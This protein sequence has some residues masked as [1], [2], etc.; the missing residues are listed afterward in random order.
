M[1]R[2]ITFGTFDLFHIGHLKILER[3]KNYSSEQNVL[4][5]GVSSDELNFKK[6]QQYPCIN[7]NHRK[8]IVSSLRVV[9]EVFTEYKLEDKLKYC[10]DHKADLLIM[11]DDHLNEYEYL[12][13]EIKDFN[14][15]YL[16]RTKNISTT[17]IKHELAMR[18]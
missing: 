9:D 17:E 7:L 3:S 8:E 6:K 16:P 2:V 5:V 14:V 12:K 11:G 10:K 13:E 15:V 1:K 18:K 4:I